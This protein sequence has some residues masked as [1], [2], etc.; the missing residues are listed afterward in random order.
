MS[1]Q[2]Q[3][4][5]ITIA[6]ASVL[7]LTMPGTALANGGGGGGGGGGFSNAPS[8]QPSFNPAQ[9]YREGVQKYQL[10]DFAG[11]EKDL[12]KVTREVRNNA[13]AHYMLGLT[14]MAQDKWK[15]AAGSLK[16]AVRY[17]ADLH[18]ARAKLGLA[19]MKLDKPEKAAR[20]MAEFDKQL[21]TCGEECGPK[22]VKAANELRT[23]MNPD[24]AAETVAS[25]YRPIPV[26]ISNEAGDAAYLDAVRLINI[27]NFDAALDQLHAAEAT[28]GPH[29]DVLTYLGFANRKS[30]NYAQA[31]TYYSSAL[32]IA[33]NHIGANE[34]L[35]EYYVELG[36]MDDAKAQ[37]AKLNE[38]CA[39]GCAEADE[40]RS[41]IV[42][43][44][45]S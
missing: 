15:P 45:A 7:A 29:P 9:V 30:G 33:P 28:F 8:S 43:A 32:S 35:G 22:L 23:A 3:R 39:F 44:E 24:T 37:L 13:N 27:G 36:E 40:L 41:W 34:Y 26:S 1:G 21:A 11:A 16:K 18:E 14:R 12:R 2:N 10:G 38:I 20:Q 42:K 17:D 6:T 4:R 5:L 25:L 31:I 19:Y